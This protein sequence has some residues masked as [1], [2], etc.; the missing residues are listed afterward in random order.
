MFIYCDLIFYFCHLGDD[1]HPARY[2]LAAG[3]VYVTTLFCYLVVFEGYS[4]DLCVAS[5]AC[6][7]SVSTRVEYG[8][9]RGKGAMATDGSPIESRGLAALLC[10]RRRRVNVFGWRN[11]HR[12]RSLRLGELPPR[13]REEKNGACSLHYHRRSVRTFC[14]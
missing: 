2:S 9:D 11:A 3:Q 4:G 1:R 10:V 6:D 12:G 13:D 8:A 14:P 7:W 5:W